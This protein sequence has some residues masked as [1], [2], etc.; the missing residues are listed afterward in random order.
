MHQDKKTIFNAEEQPIQEQA[1]SRNMYGKSSVNVKLTYPYSDKYEYTT[2][3]ERL[4]LDQE[5]INDL[6]SGKGFPIVSSHSIKLDVKNETGIFSRR[7]G[8]TMAD[9]K[10]SF[11]GKYHCSC[12]LTKGRIMH[13]ERCPVCG[14]IV[15][16]YDDDVSITG[17]C[18]LKDKYFVIHPNIYRSLEGFIGVNRL[19]RIIDAE[20]QVDSN[21]RIIKIGNSTGKK[22]NTAVVLGTYNKKDDPFIG[23][24]MFAFRERYDE[25]LDYYYAKYPAKKAF[26]EDLKANKDITFTRSIPIF[27]ALL[28]PSSL[29]S[30]NT[31]RYETTNENFQMI[32]RLVSM[33]NKDTLRMDQKIKEKLNILHDIQVNFNEVY[34]EIKEIIS[35]KKGDIRASIGGRYSF[36]ERSV[37]RQDPYLRADEVRLPF[38][39][40]LELLQQV[41]INIL[42][43]THNISYSA[44]YKR[45]YRAQ[46]N[47]YGYDQ[48]IYDI[49]D[50]LIKDSGGLPVLINRNPTISYGGILRCRVVGINMNYTMSISLLILKPLAADSSR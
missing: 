26:Y 30:G 43:K 12:R 39:G 44:A 23:I 31:L 40:L 25:I 17:W 20:V 11:D 6:K 24:G 3:L 36:S 45:W 48:T 33:C 41:I 14:T 47:G 1:N 8:S 10:D 38:Q 49:I 46:I 37:I 16:Y 15:K 19:A 29:D 27:S 50:G 2:Q 9:V 7:Y 28:R 4:N 5:R 18:I 34:N 35:K 13:G 21:G 32:A 22:G 42:V